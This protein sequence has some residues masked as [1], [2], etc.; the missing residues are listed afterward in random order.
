MYMH[1]VCVDDGATTCDPHCES[2]SQVK[3]VGVICMFPGFIVCS[4]GQLR[5]IVF[6]YYSVWFAQLYL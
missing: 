4:I 6:R 5:M 3:Q 1:L 2:H